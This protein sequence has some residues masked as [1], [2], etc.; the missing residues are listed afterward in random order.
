MLLFERFVK[1]GRPSRQFYACSA[2]RDRKDCAFF[3]WKDEKPT[4][5]SKQAHEDIIRRSQPSRSQVKH[6]EELSRLFLSYKVNKDKIYPW[7]FCHTCNV[8]VLN[9]QEVH[10]E[11]DLQRGEKLQELR[12]PSTI[13]KPRENVKEHAVS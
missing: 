2:C 3:L 11:H 8:I 13:L 1:D 6:C 10:E 12:H 5:S 4:A 7:M 9:N